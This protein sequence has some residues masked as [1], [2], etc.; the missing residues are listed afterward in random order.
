MRRC[1]VVLA[2]ALISVSALAGCGSADDEA[3]EAADDRSS[4]STESSDGSTPDDDKSPDD[5]DK[6][7]DGSGTGPSDD[8]DDA[9]D[10]SDAGD[11]SDAKDK[12]DEPDSDDKSDDNS[13]DKADD[14]GGD[15]YCA[16]VRSLKA[17][18]DP[19]NSASLANATDMDAIVDR[20]KDI[21][22]AAPKKIRSD[23]AALT[24][25]YTTLARQLDKYGIELTDPKGFTKL[26][27]K[28][29]KAIQAAISKT[30]KVAGSVG[31]ITANIKSTCGVTLQ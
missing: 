9:D 23:W 2:T 24:S 7:D 30:Q 26:K 8:K 20:F 31:A 18:F 22:K 4:S 25:A 21:T 19:S 27:P 11:T 6:T 5:S 16:E 14:A 10:K 12:G 1:A 3:S 17:D 28:E 15:D 29:R 13:D